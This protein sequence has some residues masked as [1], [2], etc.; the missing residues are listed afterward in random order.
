MQYVTISASIVGTVIIADTEY[1][2][3]ENRAKI[4]SNLGIKIWHPPA[5]TMANAEE[6]PP[7][8]HSGEV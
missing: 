4:A 5:S 1:L 2:C 3:I 8:W 7:M 6:I